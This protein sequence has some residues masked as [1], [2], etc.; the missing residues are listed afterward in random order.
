MQ[1]VLVVTVLF[2]AVWFVALR[3]KAPQAESPPA[4]TPAAQT[5]TPTTAS[6]GPGSSLPG[7][8]G[9]S[10][11]KARDASSASDAANAA[12]DGAEAASTGEPAT[13]ASA[14]SPSSASASPAASAGA[15]GAAA[16]K[17][18]KTAA[19]R[20]AAAPKPT[21]TPA[22]VQQAIAGGK[23]VVMLFWD[24]RTSVDRAVRLAIGTAGP[25]GRGVFVAAAPIAM[26]SKYAS[27]TRG[28]QV[29]Q[30][31]TVVVVDRRKQATLLTGFVDRGEIAQAVAD[32]R[33]AGRR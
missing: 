18:A 10:V 20:R 3:P 29:L 4:A 25:R 32:A 15:S 16:S 19:A 5:Q 30:A 7:S 8:L 24:R 9:R 28:V 13:D 22:R 12:R 6:Q 11:E 33:A 2:A 21:A 23:V 14:A 31:P 27:I 1:I 26:V 17:A